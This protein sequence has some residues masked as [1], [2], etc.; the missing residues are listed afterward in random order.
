MFRSRLS[1]G[2]LETEKHIKVTRHPRDRG[3]KHGTTFQVSILQQPCQHSQGLSVQQRRSCTVAEVQDMQQAVDRP[4]RAGGAPTAQSK[5]RRW[6]R[7]PGAG[8]AD[9]H[10]TRT[11][12][13]DRERRRRSRQP[14]RTGRPRVPRRADFWLRGAKRARVQMDPGTRREGEERG[15]TASRTLTVFGTMISCSTA[16]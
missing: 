2:A 6:P 12:Q 8:A 7:R 15:H 1:D 10:A 4:I 13:T 11:G 9:L 3:D 5:P 14:N 16:L